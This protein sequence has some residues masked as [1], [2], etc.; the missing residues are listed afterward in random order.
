MRNEIYRGNEIYII[1][2]GFRS[3]LSFIPIKSWKSSFRRKEDPLIL[4]Y[5]HANHRGLRAPIRRVQSKLLFFR[6]SINYSG[7]IVANTQ[8]RVINIGASY[9]N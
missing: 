7:V 8:Q 5:F 2:G 3:N 4:N 1:D 6:V 9:I